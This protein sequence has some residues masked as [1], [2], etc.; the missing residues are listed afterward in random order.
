[1][2]HLSLQWNVLQLTSNSYLQGFN[3]KFEYM[4]IE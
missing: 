2:P 1:M 4:Y 3:S